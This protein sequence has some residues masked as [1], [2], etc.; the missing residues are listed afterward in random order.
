[1]SKELILSMTVSIDGFIAGPNGEMDWI[2]HSMSEEGRQWVADQFWQASLIAMGHHSYLTM[3]DFWPTAAGPIARPMNEIPKVVFSRTGMISP[4]LME[5]TVAALKDETKAEDS[6]QMTAEQVLRSWLHPTIAGTD[7]IADIQRLKLEDGKP[8]LAIGG[9]SF[10]S[11]LI[12]AKLVD[13]FRLS[14]HPV[15][16]GNGIPLFGGLEAPCR[17]KLEDLRRFDSGAVVKTFR[18]V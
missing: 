5:K 11:S 12:T 4:P 1:M 8:I 9:A 14:I 18:P 15:A 2:F 3:A 6:K 7:L 17:M 13:A 10:A 16:L